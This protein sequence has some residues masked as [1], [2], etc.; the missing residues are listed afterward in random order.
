M[1]AFPDV[2]LFHMLSLLYIAI[3]FIVRVFGSAAVIFGLVHPAALARRIQLTAIIVS[4]STLISLKQDSTQ[5]HKLR[6]ITLISIS[7]LRV[8]SSYQILNLLATLRILSWLPVAA[9]SID[10]LWFI[11][12]WMRSTW[13]LLGRGCT[14]IAVF[15]RLGFGLLRYLS[16][17]LLFYLWNTSLIR[18]QALRHD[19]GTRLGVATSAFLDRVPVDFLW[20]YSWTQQ[21]FRPTDSNPAATVVEVGS[22][23]GNSSR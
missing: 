12:L 18:V 14:S 13:F 11:Q 10:L 22:I 2:T 23:E 6:A 1:L 3:T 16:R 21:F 19:A 4:L 15:G 5:S 20:P 7:L 9:S 17:W 8:I